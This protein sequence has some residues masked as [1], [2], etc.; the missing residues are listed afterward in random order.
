MTLPKVKTTALEE[1][2]PPRAEPKPIGRKLTFVMK[3]E[4][5]YDV[6]RQRHGTTDLDQCWE[7]AAEGSKWTLLGN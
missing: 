4:D 6:E 3:I 5:I 7:R 1:N 2:S